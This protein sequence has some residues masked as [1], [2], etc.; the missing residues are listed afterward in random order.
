MKK[1]WTLSLL[2]LLIQAPAFAGVVY[3]I[4]TTDHE[5]SPPKV[6]SIEMAAEGRHLK[7]GIGGGSQNTKGDMIFRGDRREVVVVDHDQKSY[8]VMDREQMQAIAGQVNSALS[9][10]QEALKNVPADQRAIV[11]KMMKERMPQQPQS[12]APRRPASELKKTSERATHNGYPCIKY[13]VHQNG[14]KLRELWVTDWKNV[15]GSSEVAQTF[16]DMADFF[17]EMMD[18]FS[19]LAG[20]AG[21]GPLPF[22]SGDNFFEHIKD[23]DGF[24]VVTK[25][26]AEDGSLEGEGAL[27]SARRQ[28]IDPDA[29]EP[30]SGYKRQ[31]MPGF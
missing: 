6:E 25:E 7:M 5:Q 18:S 29:F 11:E 1:H 12:Q 16:E 24:P 8:M 9:Q 13:E 2:A 20:A 22:G 23:L 19:S 4:E 28:T 3:E 17:R 15:E 31:E 14:K 30:P 21:G 10:M 26:F 27:R